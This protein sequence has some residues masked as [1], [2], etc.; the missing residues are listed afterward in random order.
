M[1]HPQKLNT[2]NTYKCI[3]VK[4]K[5]GKQ[6]HTTNHKPNQVQKEKKRKEIKEKTKQN[7][8]AKLRIKKINAFKVK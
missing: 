4:K 1:N 3:L 5:K 7:K 2:L 8:M 6:L